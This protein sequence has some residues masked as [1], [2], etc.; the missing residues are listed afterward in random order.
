MERVKTTGS[1]L[2]KKVYKKRNPWC[3][4]Y[5]FGHVAV[6]SG[7]WVYTGAPYLVG[8]AALRSGVDLVTVFSPERAANVV[9]SF[10]P[11]LITYPL[12]GKFLSPKHVK[13]ILDYVEQR[14]VTSLVIGNGL[15]RRN[16]SIKAVEKLL[17]N[18]DLP[19]CLDADGLLALKSLDV[20]GL[21]SLVAT[22]HAG[23][24]ANVFG[25]KVSNDVEDRINKV[26]EVAKAKS[27]VIVLKGHVDVISDGNEVWLNKTGSSYMT[28][29]GTGDVLAGVCGAMLS[30]TKDALLSACASSY[31]VSKAGEIVAKEKKAGMVASDLLHAIPTVIKRI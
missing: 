27:L 9:A 5:D 8:M 6:V 16:E 15:G 22:P 23:E 4:K 31:L 12:T 3:K 19:V 29:G 20:E 1:F 13:E 28:V 25:M 30:L 26:V 11:D 17:R 2:L 24:F 18:V 10:S 7:S 14:K 21:P